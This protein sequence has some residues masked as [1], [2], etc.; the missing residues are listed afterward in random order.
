MVKTDNLVSAPSRPAQVGGETGGDE[1]L[2]FGKGFSPPV[3][4]LR[5]VS[6]VGGGVGAG[7]RG[8]DLAETDGLVSAPSRPAPGRGARSAVVGI[9]RGAW[10]EGERGGGGEKFL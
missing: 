2:V 1:T 4:P 8:R 3:P 7:R 10:N 9:P 6:R 5:R